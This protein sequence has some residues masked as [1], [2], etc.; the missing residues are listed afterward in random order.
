MAGFFLDAKIT[1]YYLVGMDTKTSLLDSAEMLARQRGFDAFSYA[2]LSRAVGIRKASIH[3]HFPTKADLAQALVTRYREAFMAALTG[4]EVA[5]RTA[6]S[7]LSA[8]L[9]LYKSAMKGGQQVCLCVSFS[10]SLDSFDPQV[11]RQVNRFHAESL[12]WLERVFEK[13]TADGSIINV[14]DLADEAYACLA[15]AEGAQL[16]ARASGEIRDF[17]TAVKTLAAR[18]R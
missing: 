11:V 7:Q 14:G 8:Y 6:G 10:V 12:A 18:I 1:T 15:L 17:E 13:G 5:E 9:E 2:D 4:I 16:I 3:H